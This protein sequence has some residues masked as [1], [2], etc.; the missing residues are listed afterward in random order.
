M[1]KKT[2]KI[3]NKYNAWVT[4]DIIYDSWENKDYEN[5][6]VYEDIEGN[7]ISITRNEKGEI[8]DAWED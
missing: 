7:V 5:T 6:T 2:Q 8:I 1:T 4:K 3:I